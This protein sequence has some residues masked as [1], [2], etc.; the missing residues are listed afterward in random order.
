MKIKVKL[1]AASANIYVDAYVATVL[2][3]NN[4]HY[5]HWYVKGKKFDT[6]HEMANEYYSKL[7]DAVDDIA[8]LC[9]QHNIKI[10]NPSDVAIDR[11]GVVLRD[12]DGFSYREAITQM[13][14]EITR[15]LNYIKKLADSSSTNDVRN[16]QSK[17]DD[18]VA[19][20]SKELNYKIK[21]RLKEI[22]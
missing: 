5:I 13:S 22:D 6:V 14:V 21:N 11:D 2:A 15:Y 20:W 18:I 17:L 12:N 7:Q 19:Y 8:E 9:L 3:A 10:P 1:F 4:I 16:E